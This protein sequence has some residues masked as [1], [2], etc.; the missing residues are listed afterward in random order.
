MGFQNALS[1]LGSGVNAATGI[2]NAGGLSK[3]AG[4][5]F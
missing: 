3:I 1:L 4:S 5:F 2:T